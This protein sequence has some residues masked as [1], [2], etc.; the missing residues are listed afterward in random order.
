MTERS[1]LIKIIILQDFIL[2]PREISIP[3]KVIEKIDFNKEIF[4]KFGAE[5]KRS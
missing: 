3:K 5:K 4:F 2:D 1:S